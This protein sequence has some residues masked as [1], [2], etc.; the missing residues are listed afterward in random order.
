MEQATQMFSKWMKT[1][2]DMTFVLVNDETDDLGFR[3]QTYEQL[4]NGIRLDGAG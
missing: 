3:H 1:N 2:S 4:M